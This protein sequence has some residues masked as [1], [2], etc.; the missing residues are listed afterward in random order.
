MVLSKEVE[1][2]LKQGSNVS[3]HCI[4]KD[5]VLSVVVS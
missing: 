5:S 1:I 4:Y 3:H 2:V